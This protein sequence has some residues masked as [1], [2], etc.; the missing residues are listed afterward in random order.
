MFENERIKETQRPA[1]FD[2][3]DELALN[4]VIILEET[5]HVN[6]ESMP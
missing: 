5:G 1:F 6:S 3:Y 4:A 2:V